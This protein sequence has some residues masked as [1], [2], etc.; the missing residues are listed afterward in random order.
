MGYERRHRRVN[1]LE[2]WKDNKTKRYQ[3]P[4][5]DLPWLNTPAS[6]SQLALFSLRIGFR[7]TASWPVMRRPRARSTFA[8]RA[9][10][11][12]LSVFSAV[13]TKRCF[14]RGLFSKRS[15]PS[16]R[17]WISV[18]LG[19]PLGKLAAVR[20]EGAIEGVPLT[21]EN[22]LEVRF[23]IELDITVGT[24]GIP[25]EL[26]ELVIIGLSESKEA[27]RAIVARDEVFFVGDIDSWWFCLYF[28]SRWVRNDQGKYY[29][30]SEGPTRRTKF[31]VDEQ[32]LI[33]I[34]RIIWLA[35]GVEKWRTGLRLI[36]LI[37]DRV[38]WNIPQWNE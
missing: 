1:L 36:G 19:S 18:S 15:K 16:P 23:Y 30:S 3:T 38:K 2:K 10:L 14:W 28:R 37:K 6:V 24:T 35:W 20:S 26:T 25:K 22:L 7:M 29:T 27:G 8:P 21:V 17:W 11:F 12:I 34:E 9:S 13:G 5:E 33:L 32:I 4:A 31:A